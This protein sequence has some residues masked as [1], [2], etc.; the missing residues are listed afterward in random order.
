VTVRTLAD[1]TLRR[2]PV[3]AVFRRRTANRLAVLAYHGVDDPAQLA[4][5]LD[6]LVAR[7]RPVDL[8]TVVGALHEGDPLPERAV[9]VTFDDGHR[10]VL[11]LGLPLLRERGVPAVAFVLPGLLGTDRPFWWHE[12]GA[13]VDAGGLADGWQ[14]DAASVVR[15]LKQVPDSERRAV[16]DALRRSA[17][18][19][20]ARQPQLRVDELRL[21]EAGGVE[22]GNHTWDHPCLDRCTDEVVRAEVRDGH[23]ALTDALG[24]A[25][26]AFAYPNGNWDPRAEHELRGLGYRAAF[27]FDHRLATVPAANPL[28]LSRLR[29]NSDTSLDRFDTVIT[30]LHPA[31]H[32]ARGRG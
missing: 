13:L 27:L 7:A 10:S 28:R 2:S 5:Q 30:G 24:R 20:G 32:H 8:D 23:A 15:R 18:G 4:R 9:L 3:Q 6:L 14:G 1:A 29:V 12:T 21:L 16:L 31:L 22:V 26:R 19:P 17:T 11:E 25:P